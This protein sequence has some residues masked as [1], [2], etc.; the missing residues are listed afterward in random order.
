MA[1][2][3]VSSVPRQVWALRQEEVVLCFQK[4]FHADWFEGFKFPF[5]EDLVKSDVFMDYFGWLHSSG[6]EW[7]KPLGPLESTRSSRMRQ[8]MSEGR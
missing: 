1:G 3:V 7:D 2:A 4:L 6:L 8:R 5:I